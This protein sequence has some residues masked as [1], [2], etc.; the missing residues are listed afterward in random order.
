MIN[1]KVPV[2][3]YH[4]YVDPCN[5]NVTL[6][7][8]TCLWQRYVTAYFTD[9]L[10]RTSLLITSYEANVWLLLP[11]CLSEGPEYEYSGSEEDEDEVTEEE[12][13]PR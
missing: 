13:E 11:L 12:G 9:L 8:V 1:K 3:W 2:N 10:Y 4:I 7:V 5:L 6:N